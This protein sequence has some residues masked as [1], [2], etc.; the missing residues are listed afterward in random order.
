NQIKADITGKPILLP[1]LMDS[2]LAGDLCLALFALRQFD[3]LVQASDEIVKIRQV[4]TPDY[5]N[6]K[7]YDDFFHI[8]REAYSGL[9]KVFKNL[10]EIRYQERI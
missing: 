7:I 8:Y 10:S 9:K 2:D 6:K 5:K 3:T 1:D 4:Y